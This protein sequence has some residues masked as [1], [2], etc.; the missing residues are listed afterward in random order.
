RGRGPTARSRDRLLQVQPEGGV[1]YV[2][3]RSSQTQSRWPAAFVEAIAPEIDLGNLTEGFDYQT[4][5]CQRIAGLAE[6]LRSSN[7]VFS[8]GGVR[9]AGEEDTPVHVDFVPC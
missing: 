6:R 9:E 3:A 1:G 7:T 4:A 8:L 2:I 5:E